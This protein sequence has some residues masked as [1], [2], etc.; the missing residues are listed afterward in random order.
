[1][2]ISVTATNT[3]I[4]IKTFLP[5]LP[6]PGIVTGAPMRKAFIIL[7]ALFL[8]PFLPA[9]WTTV[10]V[11]NQS[12]GIYALMPV[13]TVYDWGCAQTNLWSTPVI[14]SFATVPI[15][16]WVLGS[17]TNSPNPDPKCPSGLVL[18]VQQTSVKQ[19]VQ[20]II[21][22]QPI[23]YVTVSAAAVPVPI[24]VPVVKPAPTPTMFNP[25]VWTCTVT[26]TIPLTGPP[27]APVD[28][29]KCTF[30]KAVTQ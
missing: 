29:T 28:P 16:N 23:S 30:V 11:N 12:T 18:R 22:G 17:T 8:T 6:M 9:Q 1:L 27:S 24:P 14:V 3:T 19:V 20:I 10:T 13:G 4:P 26:I 21:P 5:V 7:A 25:S 2:R 15:T